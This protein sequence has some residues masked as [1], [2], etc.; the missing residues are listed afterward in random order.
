MATSRTSIR[1]AC[2]TETVC[3]A[4][5]SVFSTMTPAT[6][7]L[8]PRSRL[9]RLPDRRGRCHEDYDRLV[10]DLAGLSPR[11]HTVGSGGMRGLRCVCGEPA[12]CVPATPGAPEHLV[13]GR[14]PP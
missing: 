12:R 14:R 4:V 8:L 5:L 11:V 9:P 13:R 7:H 3:R 10:Q 1:I 6:A 2:C